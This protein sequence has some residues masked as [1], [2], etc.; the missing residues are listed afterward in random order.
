MENLGSPSGLTPD[1]PPQAR[2]ETT[3]VSAAALPHLDA[4]GGGGGS[5]VPANGAGEQSCQKRN[6]VS[7][8]FRSRLSAMVSGQF[9]VY[10]MKT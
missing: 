9:A 6:C 7:I 1:V 5:P 2:T 3:A 8:V 10:E 4:V